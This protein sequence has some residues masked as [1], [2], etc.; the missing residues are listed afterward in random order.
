[1]NGWFYGTGRPE[2]PGHYRVPGDYPAAAALLAAAA[3]L[4]SRVTLTNLA[5]NDRQGEKAAL[6]HLEKM[7]AE[8]RRT[9]RGV[10]IRG[11]QQLQ[12]VDF[13]GADA[14]DAVLAMAAAATLAEGT[15]RF[16]GVG[17]LRWKESDRIG[18]FARELRKAGVDVK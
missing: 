8:L 11:G 18:D 17:N 4:S 3:V 2:C 12:A 15:S 7:G 13:Y 14:I 9:D 16:Y 1:M 5:A 10:E 6:T